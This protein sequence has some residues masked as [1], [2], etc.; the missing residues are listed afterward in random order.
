MGQFA[1]DLAGI[2]R[3]LVRRATSS[4]VKYFLPSLFPMVPHIFTDCSWVCSRVS[5]P[6]N[7]TLAIQCHYGSFKSVCTIKTPN[8][9]IMRL[10]VLPTALIIAFTQLLSVILGRIRQPRVI[11]EVIGGVLLGPTVLGRIPGSL[12]SP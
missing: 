9:E 10:F 2:S 1:N 8:R 7:T 6:Q 12:F 3:G 5:T 4:P 11:A